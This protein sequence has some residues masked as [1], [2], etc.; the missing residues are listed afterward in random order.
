MVWNFGSSSTA[1]TRLTPTSDPNR[2]V[3]TNITT[4]PSPA[5]GTGAGSSPFDGYMPW[6]GME[7]YNII[8]NAVSYKKGESGFSRS[9][10]DTMVY[11]PE[12]YYKIVNDTSNSKRYFYIANGATTGFTKHPGSGK[13]VGKYNTIS[14]YYSKTA[15]APLVSITRAAARTGS[16]NKGSKWSQY[17]YATWCAIWL[18]YLVEFADW[19]SQTKIGRGVVDESSQI[20]NGATDSMTYHT[21][22]ASG[23]DGTTA[24]L[25]RG[26]ENLWGN[27]Y[28]WV[29]GIN[30]NKR[31][32]YI[33]TDRSKYADGTSS[34][35]MDTGFS[36]PVS[37][38]YI[39]TLSVYSGADWAFIPTASGGSASTYVPDNVFL[40]VLIWAGLC[41]GGNSTIED[42]AGL[43]MFNAN[44]S[45][46]SSYSYVGARLLFNP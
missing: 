6:A 4:N 24:V 16:K 30:V 31:K 18:L 38:G 13:Y 43:F 8:N 25:Y 28:D 33:C 27:I 7:E 11:I 15:A 5:V 9:S 14:G 35:Y 42:P 37:L 44:F 29:D 45:A 17:D 41:I 32:V 36:L 19:N 10:Y 21:G 3:N 12:F 20:N 40:N 26:I 22:R 1:L 46:T 2:Y 34:N 23:T 39:K